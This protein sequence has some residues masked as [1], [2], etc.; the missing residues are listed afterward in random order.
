MS[1]SFTNYLPPNKRIN[2]Y[3]NGNESKRFKVDQE[4]W[5]HYGYTTKG[6]IERWEVRDG[7]NIY[8]KFNPEN[9]SKREDVQKFITLHNVISKKNKPQRNFNVATSK[10]QNEKSKLRL[11]IKAKVKIVN[12]P[13][14][15]FESEEDRVPSIHQILKGEIREY[16]PEET[17]ASKF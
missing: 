16:E 17:K 3:E 12:Q 9:F 10:N 8:S 1:I 4:T 13:E 11:E 7:R 6:D 5:T 14:N 2:P 15:H